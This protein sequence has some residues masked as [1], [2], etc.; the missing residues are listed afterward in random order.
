MNKNVHSSEATEKI[1]VG[2]ILTIYALAIGDY[3]QDAVILC[4][5]RENI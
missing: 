3:T 4:M 2:E 5:L 1:R